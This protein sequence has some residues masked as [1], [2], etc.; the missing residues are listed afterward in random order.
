MEIPKSLKATWDVVSKDNKIDKEDYQKLLDTAAPTGKNGEFEDD[1]IAFLASLKGD[2][3]KSDSKEGVALSE[4]SFLNDADQFEW[5]GYT[6]EAIAEFKDTYKDLAIGKS[7]PYL[8]KEEGTKIAVAFGK[9]DIA[10]LQAMVNAKAD[11]KF[12]PETLF[13]SRSYLQDLVNK[14]TDPA[15]GE[16]INKMAESVGLYFQP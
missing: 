15:E 4:I 9:S 13:K 5:K 16:K 8:S 12:G 2:L 10:E 3:E 7:I 11:G 14:T 1:E 6:K